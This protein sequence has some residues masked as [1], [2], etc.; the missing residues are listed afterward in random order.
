[1]VWIGVVIV[2]KERD[3]FEGFLRGRVGSRESEILFW[4]GFKDIVF[5]YFLSSVNW[6][7]FLRRMEVM[8][9]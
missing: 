3:C 5:I 7:L 9:L 4:W 6:V 2:L 8:D 1:M